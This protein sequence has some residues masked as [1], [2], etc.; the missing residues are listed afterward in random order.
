MNRPETITSEEKLR[1]VQDYIRFHYDEELRLSTLAS[2]VNMA[3]S[4]F[5]RFFKRQTGV[6]LRDYIADV[7][8]DAVEHKLMNTDAMICDMSFQCGFNTLSN[9]NRL[10][11]RRYGCNPTEYKKN[12]NTKTL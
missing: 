5:C 11:R 7:R 9:F 1:K 6:H 10:F 2:M 8:L 12:K 4:T 3:T